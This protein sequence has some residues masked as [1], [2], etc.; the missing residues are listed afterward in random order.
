MTIILKDTILCEKFANN[1]IIRNFVWRHIF[2]TIVVHRFR[3]FLA[4]KQDNMGLRIEDHVVLPSAALLDPDSA[5][6][7]FRHQST[8]GH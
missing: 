4:T 1:L 7:T 8:T 6:F 2:I 3:D 5:P